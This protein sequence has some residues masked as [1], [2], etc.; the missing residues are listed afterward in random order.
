[1]PYLVK[2]QRTEYTPGSPGSPG[3]PGSPARPS[4][5]ENRCAGG[6]GSSSG[7]S[8]PTE[9]IC[10]ASPMLVTV[11]GDNGEVIDYDLLS[12]CYTHSSRRR[13]SGGSGVSRDAYSPNPPSCFVYHPAVA[14]QPAIPATPRTPGYTL[15][16]DQVGWNS[17]AW[18]VEQFGVGQG[19]EFTPVSGSR[20]ILVAISEN[21]GGVIGAIQ[22]VDHALLIGWDGVR[23]LERGVVVGTLPV[24]TGK[25]RI[26][27]LDDGRITFATQ[28]AVIRGSLLAPTATYFIAVMLYQARDGIQDFSF[29]EI[30]K[31]YASGGFEVSGF[32]SDGYARATGLIEISGATFAATAAGT[33]QKADGYITIGGRAEMSFDAYM[34]GAIPEF[35]GFSGNVN[36]GGMRGEIP[37]FVGYS[38][39]GAF[40]MSAPP[41]MSGSM[42]TFFGVSIGHSETAAT[43]DGSLP[44]FTG[45]S[46][47]GAYG[48]VIGSM[49]TFVGLSFGTDDT[50]SL[51]TAN[52]EL[53]ISWSQVTLDGGVVEPTAYTLTVVNQESVSSPITLTKSSLITVLNELSETSAVSAGF[54]GQI[55]VQTTINE[56]SGST[57]RVAGVNAVPSEQVWVLNLDS[58][59]TSRYT[60]YGFNS[61]LTLNGKQYGVSDDGLYELGTAN[62]NGDIID[63]SL[64]LAVSQLDSVREKRNYSVYAAVSS[65]DTMLLKVSVDGGTEYLYEARSSSAAM[66]THRFDLGRGLKGT[67]WTFTLM[68]NEGCD[69]DLQNLEFLPIDGKRRI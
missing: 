42:P 31:A 1:M 59:A 45:L 60:D 15:Y 16:D 48:E 43:M 52:M 54:A 36:A 14:A 32:A 37:E 34:Q 33:N 10:Y 38:A 12:G 29:Y 55:V 46:V 20:G 9:T 21:T 69:F 17:I 24:P 65:T 7:S 44:E 47:G 6:T 68:N 25:T 30:G 39:Q 23:V 27:R 57:L 35:V 64:K 66:Q 28:A 50:S 56:R 49:P 19:F 13:S 58:G 41:G 3:Y 11:R 4:W 26:E 67:H 5:V 8:D 63:A 40:E 51:D 2:T 18:T 62:D 53:L 61:Y 22:D